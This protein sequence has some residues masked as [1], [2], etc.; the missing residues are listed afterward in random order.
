MLCGEIKWGAFRCAE[1]FCLPSHQENFGIVVAEALACGTPVAIAEP[2]NIAAEVE[3]AGA[4]LVHADTVAGTT[5]ALRQWLALPTD[6]AAQMGVRG[7]QLFADTFD[8]ASVART[9]M[10]VLNFPV[11][12]H[13]SELDGSQ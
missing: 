7:A 4:G 9:L 8:F 5:D 3:A 13:A 12:D 10:P 1:L 6:H 11:S 2:V